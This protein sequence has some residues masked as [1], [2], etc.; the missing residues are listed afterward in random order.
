MPV[1]DPLLTERFLLQ[2][3]KMHDLRVESINT[4]KERLKKLR[5]WIHVNRPAIQNAVFADFERNAVETDGIE[6]F[7]VLSE[8]KHALSNLDLWAATKKVDAPLTMLG[9][10]SYLRYEPR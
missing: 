4:R 2:K 5:Q 7:N 6:I 9:T 1:S 8:I 10:R 3:K